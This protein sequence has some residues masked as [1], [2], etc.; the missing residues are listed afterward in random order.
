M[1]DVL[2][3]NDSGD[4]PVMSALSA[5][6]NG[7]YNQVPF[8]DVVLDLLDAFHDLFVVLP[9]AEYQQQ[10]ASIAT[11]QRDQ[12]SELDMLRQLTGLGPDDGEITYATEEDCK[13]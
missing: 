1:G 8:V 11:K 12:Q 2:S 6:Y 7:G 4:D 13:R 10:L 5:A 9:K 3:V